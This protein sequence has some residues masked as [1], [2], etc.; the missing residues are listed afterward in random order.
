MTAGRWAAVTALLVASCAVLCVWIVMRDRGSDWRP[1]ERQAARNDA[2]TLLL[3][4][5]GWHCPHR[6][7]VE[8]LSRT[9]PNA[10][11]ARLALPRGTECYEIAILRFSFSA[12]HG[13]SGVQRATCAAYRVG[14]D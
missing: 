7:R 2:H 9:A 4:L 8:G 6:C 1:P 5:R 3:G 13:F 14:S 11:L 12:Q 10:W